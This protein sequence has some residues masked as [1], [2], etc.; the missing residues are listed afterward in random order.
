MCLSTEQTVDHKRDLF[1]RMQK[2]KA[3]SP[4]GRFEAFLKDGDILQLGME[5]SVNRLRITIYM[6]E[7]GL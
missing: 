5:E 4:T 2:D 7:D 1:C 6:G 3:E